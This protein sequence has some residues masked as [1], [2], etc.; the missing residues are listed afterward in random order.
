MIALSGVRVAN[1]RKSG[2][3]TAVVTWAMYWSM[4]PAIIG[5]VLTSATAFRALFV[6]RTPSPARPPRR[7][8]AKNVPVC[9]DAAAAAAPLRK[10]AGGVQLAAVP[11][12]CDGGEGGG[13]CVR[14]AHQL[15]PSLLLSSASSATAQG[16]FA[17]S[18]PADADSDT[19]IET[20][21][22]TTTSAG[23]RPSRRGWRRWFTESSGWRLPASLVPRGTI[24]GLHTDIQEVG[25][26]DISDDVEAVVGGDKW[27]STEAVSKSADIRG[28]GV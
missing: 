22:L 7:A 5:L 17:R 3:S 24:T 23:A 4:A 14:S 10:S 13:A 21:T 6:A 9:D 28:L 15:P 16:G 8:A 2:T 27:A 1:V 26:A 12:G 19:Y 20:G 25:A 11:G 18:P